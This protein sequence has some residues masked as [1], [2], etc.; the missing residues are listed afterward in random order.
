MVIDWDPAMTKA[1]RKYILC[2]SQRSGSTV[3]CRL[4]K[5]TGVLGAPSEY[6]AL[7]KLE[8]SAADDGG[9]AVVRT[10]VKRL[11]EHATPNGITGAKLHF[12]QFETFVGSVPL[13]AFGG[14]DL[15]VYVDRRDVFAQAV[16]LAR[17]RQT[18]QYNSRQETQGEAYY[19]F[20]SIASAKR[21]LD[22]DKAGWRTYFEQNGIRPLVVTYEDIVGDP[23]GAVGVVLGA[24]GETGAHSVTLA[25]V[26]LDIQRTDESIE[27]A[28]RFRAEWQEREAGA[29]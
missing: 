12:H 10:A 29:A 11:R 2:S 24:F 6:L 9:Q 21:H 26:K 17:A 1:L 22:R 4:L 18:K 14:F 15:W 3:Y 19:S 25:S 23:G 8:D 7:G 28:Q 27:W 5:M 16:S 20:D 13:D